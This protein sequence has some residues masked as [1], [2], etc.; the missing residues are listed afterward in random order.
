MKVRFLGTGAAEAIPSPFCGCTTCEDARKQGGRNR[1]RRSSLLINEDLLID[2]GPDLVSACAEL[3]V[4]LVGLRYLLVTHSHFDHFDPTNIEI[5][6]PRYRKVAMPKLTLVAGPS[7]LARVQLPGYRDRDVELS[8]V[9]FRPDAHVELG[10]YSVTAIAAAH[11]HDLGDAM[12][13][14]VSDGAVTVLYAVDTSEY[15]EETFS[16]LA[17][18][19]L[20][21]LIV[22]ATKGTNETSRN[23]LSIDGVLALVERLRRSGSLSPASRV[24]ATHF[25][26]S[27]VPPHDELEL[28]LKKHGILCAYDGLQI[29]CAALPG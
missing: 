23:H 29:D 7:T 10:S 3:G 16:R 5:R 9:P 21:L 14:I 17:S 18:R 8:R 15:S 11:A 25:S 24:V 22:D 12:N 28:V 27:H 4:S 26:H 6:A 13:F 20:D 1:R 19:K 2:A